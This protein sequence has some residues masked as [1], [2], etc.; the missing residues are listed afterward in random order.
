MVAS[1]V[2]SS[3]MVNIP[4]NSSSNDDDENNNAS[5]EVDGTVNAPENNIDDDDLCISD[6]E[7]RYVD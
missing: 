1:D 5:Q 4:F 3:E 2:K 6:E 7:F